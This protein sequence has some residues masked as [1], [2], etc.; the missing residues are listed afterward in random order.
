M[1]QCELQRFKKFI[2]RCKFF[3]TTQRRL[4]EIPRPR[5]FAEGERRNAQSSP[6]SVARSRPFRVDAHDDANRQP[7]TPS[8]AAKRDA[9]PT[10]LLDRRHHRHLRP[11]ISASHPAGGEI[12]QILAPHH[13]PAR[14]G[15]GWASSTTSRKEGEI[16]EPGIE[17]RLRQRRIR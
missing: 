12:R 9:R 13:R 10:S 8:L 15:D 4:L 11:E 17:R 6:S 5:D 16:A 7:G 2:A 14:P 3:P 1:R